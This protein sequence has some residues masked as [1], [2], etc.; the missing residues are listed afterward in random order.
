MTSK[1]IPQTSLNV[2]QKGQTG[3]LT[4]P[5]EKGTTQ[6]GTLSYLTGT[7]VCVYARTS[8]CWIADKLYLLLLLQLSSL[9]L[10]WLLPSWLIII[11]VTIIIIIVILLLLSLLLFYYYYHYCYY[12]YYYVYY[13][14]KAY[15]GRYLLRKLLNS[16]PR[17]IS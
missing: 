11:I 12:Y 15:V 4:A 9:L 13:H 16:S 6:K 8:I 7:Y 17:G 2:P 10:L 1:K 14:F 5:T 3:S